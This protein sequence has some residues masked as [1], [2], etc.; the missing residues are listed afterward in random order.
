MTAPLTLVV[1][2]APLTARTPDVAGALVAAGWDVTVVGSPA[3]RTWLDLDAIQAV[4]GSPVVLDQRDA[5][6][7]RGSRPIAVVACPLTLNSAS[8]AATAVMDTYATGVLGDALGAGLPLTV[9]LTVS[10]RLWPH[11]AWAGHLATLDRAGTRFVNPLTGMAGAPE[12][13]QSGTGPDVVAG[14]SPDALARVVGS[15]PRS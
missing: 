13:V 2:G 15:P 3:S 10:S 9:V 12:P 11:P 8:K 6:Q 4:T 1:C 7:V 5:G 14:F